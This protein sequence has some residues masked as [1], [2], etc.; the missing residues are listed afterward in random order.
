MKI[1]TF[2]YDDGGWQDREIMDMHE[3]CGAPA[4]FYLSSALLVESVYNGMRISEIADM[5]KGELWE[6]GAHGRTHRRLNTLGS[7]DLKWEVDGCA[8]DLQRMFGKRPECFAYPYGVT[9]NTDHFAGYGYRWAR[10]CR[11]SHPFTQQ[12]GSGGTAYA[13]PVSYIIGDAQ[14]DIEHLSRQIL[15]GNPVHIVGH[16]WEIVHKN[17][18]TELR[19]LMRS[20]LEHDYS[21]VFNSDFFSITERP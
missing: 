9:C 15:S 4:T 1:A 21:I 6:V 7:A 13:Q 17:R 5:Y 10:T 12:R 18:Q 14:S 19:S 3:M 8:D 11:R 16:A 20:V 2:S